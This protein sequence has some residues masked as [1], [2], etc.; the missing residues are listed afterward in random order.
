[1]IDHDAAVLDH[2]DARI[3]QAPGG[4][5]VADAE[6]HPDTPGSLGQ[7]QDLVDVAG[8]VGAGPKQVHQVRGF[9][10]L[11]QP[12][13]AGFAQ[14][15]IEAWVDGEDPVALRLHIAGHAVGVVVAA[16]LDSHHRDGSDFTQERVQ[17]G[18]VFDHG[19]RLLGVPLLGRL[20]GESMARGVGYRVMPGQRA[21][22]KFGLAAAIAV[23]WA[24]GVAAEVSAGSAAGRVR[25]P[26]ERLRETTL[27]NGLRVLTLEDHA[28]P[29]VSLQ[30]WVEVGSKDESR[31]T[32]L[33]HLFEHMMFKGSKHVEPEAH[34]RMIEARGGRVNAFTSRD[35]T[36][37]FEDVT[38]ESLPLVI[39]LE[40]ERFAHLV[41]TE[42][43]L[44]PERQVVLE[45]RRMRI[46]DNPGGLGFEA[47]AALTWRANTYRR[48][49]IGWR[50]DVQK[51]PASVCRAFFS[52]YYVPNNMVMVIVGDF[53]TEETL[54]HVTRAFG[55]LESSQEVPRNPIRE[56]EQKGPRRTT[57]E[58]DVKGPLLFAAWHAPA[59]GHPDAEPLD[60]ASQI[61][62]AGKSSRLYRG[63]VDE[64]QQALY[65][66]GGYW[67]LQD[68]GLFYATAGV[69]PG[70]DIAQVEELF[71]QEVERIRRGGVE[72]DEVAKA[73][74]QL[75]VSLVE[76]L[77][78]NHAL[79]SRIGRETLAF[80][81][82]RP[83]DERLDA[84]RRVTAADVQ[85][86]VRTYLR[87]E[88]RSV[89]WVVPPQAISAPPSDSGA[90]P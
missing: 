23:V 32:G 50:E 7:G 49:V 76:G 89:V 56:P 34:A 52:D 36:V 42:E 66:Q 22:W 55:I 65:A 20:W 29:V 43:S 63:L 85:R 5:V 61:L 26:V 73:K 38:S 12:G 68:A 40:A 21:G 4:R 33:A 24:L 77:T 90:T 78:T 9:G 71:F 48:P 3:R 15:G 2:G 13:T 16:V 81:R 25:D 64:A 87:P 39:D 82:V 44:A 72:E 58:F 88:K 45:E 11:S 80:G 41:I 84:I 28:T 70:R 57:V 8:N 59:T 1:M 83:L 67:E 62:S 47:L 69:R 54:D 6:L 35:V 37:Y 19:E 53:D 31:Y 79:A 75:E 74:R 17:A 51:A 60:V 30:I 86:V 14:D 27:D 46:D 18:F 10:E